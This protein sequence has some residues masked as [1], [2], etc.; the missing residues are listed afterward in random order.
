MCSGAS[1]ALYAAYAAA[2]IGTAYTAIESGK[3]QQ[4]AAEKQAQAEVNRAAYEADAAKAQAEKVRKMGR[5]QQGEANAALAASGVKLGEG[6]ALEVQKTI[7]TNTEEDALSAL[8]SGKRITAAG[9]EQADMLMTA[10]NNAM[11]NGYMSAASTVLQSGASMYGN[12][13]MKKEG[14]SQKPSKDS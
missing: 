12:W 5:A 3:Q 6:T 7:T 2:A 13:L 4:K 1:Y 9:N 10:G 8:L 14:Q 11:K